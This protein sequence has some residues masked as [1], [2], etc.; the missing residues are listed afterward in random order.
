MVLYC[1]EF[2]SLFFAEKGTQWKISKIREAKD[3][4]EF[5]KSSYVFLLLF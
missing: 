2:N 3:I 4:I 1:V 5:K